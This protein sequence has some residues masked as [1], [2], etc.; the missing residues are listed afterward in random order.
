MSLERDV[1]PAVADDGKLFGLEL[2]GPFID[3]GVPDDYR[4]L[5]ADWPDLFGGLGAE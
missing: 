4:R 5:E 1:L 2:D 3:I